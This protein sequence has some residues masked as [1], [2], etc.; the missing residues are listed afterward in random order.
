MAKHL[1]QWQSLSWVAI[2]FVKR[3][4][5]LPCSK[6][7]RFSVGYC[8]SFG[9][10]SD[11]CTRLSFPS[12]RHCFSANPPPASAPASTSNRC[13]AEAAV[14]EAL[15]TLSARPAKATATATASSATP[16]IP[17]QQP[18]MMQQAL[19]NFT[20][21][22][23]SSFAQKMQLVNTLTRSE[24]L[25]ETPTMK[26]EQAA[27]PK[28]HLARRVSL[29]G[30]EPAAK[31]VRTVSPPT[32]TPPP[33]NQATRVSSNDVCAPANGGEDSATTVEAPASSICPI[34]DRQIKGLGEHK[35][36]WS[37]P[38]QG[39]QRAK[40]ITS[41]KKHVKDYHE[42][43]PIWNVIVNSLEAAPSG[44]KSNSD[45]SSVTSGS[46]NSRVVT[47]QAFV[48]Q[49]LKKAALDQI[50][51]GPKELRSLSWTQRMLDQ[52]IGIAKGFIMFGG[53]EY[54]R[55]KECQDDQGNKINPKS[56]RN[57]AYSLLQSMYDGLMEA[58]TKHQSMIESGMATASLGLLRNRFQL[59][60]AAPD[61]WSESWY[62]DPSKYSSSC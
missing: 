30:E 44:S 6:F 48:T 60:F 20:S 51:N 19:A 45:C 4:F 39:R 9:G 7:R 1:R 33:S 41:I 46:A 15:L 59:L 56:L 10:D 27:P 16:S 11:S 24:M 49:A 13:S 40:T 38:V 53:Q 43:E 35:V 18:A 57:L 52:R 12:Y 8:A 5:P 50:P 61:K 37:Q 28:P 26:Q 21:P 14:T 36:D 22:T 23:T 25:L 3:L 55:N 32:V 2:I 31:K 29:T 58:W 47:A 34:C 17:Q 42:N 54:L 62:M